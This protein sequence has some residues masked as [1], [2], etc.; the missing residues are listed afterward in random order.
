MAEF[1]VIIF[2]LFYGNFFLV[3]FLSPLICADYYSYMNVLSSFWTSFLQEMHHTK[4]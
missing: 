3:S 1:L 2:N 4:G